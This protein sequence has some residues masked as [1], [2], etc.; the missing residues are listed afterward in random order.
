MNTNTNTNTLTKLIPEEENCKM[1]DSSPDRL[2]SGYKL[3]TFKNGICGFCVCALE[4][5]EDEKHEKEFPDHE[6][7]DECCCCIGCGCCECKKEETDKKEEESESDDEEETPTCG[8]C[9]RDAGHSPIEHH[10]WDELYFCSEK[11]YKDYE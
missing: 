6:R 3:A 10:K 5:A 9:G 7:C 8:F 11:C 2:Y 1:C 4:D